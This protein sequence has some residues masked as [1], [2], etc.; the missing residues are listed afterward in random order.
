MAAPVST[1]DG[2]TAASSSSAGTTLPSHPPEPALNLDSNVASELAGEKPQEVA[3][4]K[5]TIVMQEG[6]AMDPSSAEYQRRVRQLE[7]DVQSSK[8]KSARNSNTGMFKAM[9][10]TDLLFLIDT[11]A[12][13]MGHINAAKTQVRNI[14][15][16]VMDAFFGDAEI[17]VAVVG[18]KVRTLIRK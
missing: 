15:D 3:Q 7:R 18:Y 12:S 8:I 17:R 10:S 5:H 14:V 16:G 13:M 11:T 2:I 9:C 6:A 1:E 4:E